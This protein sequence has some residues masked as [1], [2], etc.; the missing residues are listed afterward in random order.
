LL[1]ASVLAI[2]IVKEDFLLRI[3]LS[4]N[5]KT[6]FG[7]MRPSLADLAATYSSKP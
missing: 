4:E 2:N 3:I 7:M 6:T 5:R 1:D